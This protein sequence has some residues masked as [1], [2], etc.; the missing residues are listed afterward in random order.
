M[1]A[2][3][4]D[5]SPGELFPKLLGHLRLYEVMYCHSAKV[6]DATSPLLAFAL[7]DWMDAIIDAGVLKQAVHPATQAV[8]WE[9]DCDTETQWRNDPES[10][11]NWVDTKL[12]STSNLDLGTISEERRVSYINR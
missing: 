9:V 1:G 4:N 3:L 2:V 8:T 12:Y 6:W 10:L 5:L 11:I 7:E